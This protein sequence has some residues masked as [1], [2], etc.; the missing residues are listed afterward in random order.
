MQKL[1]Q[2]HSE[3]YSSFISNLEKG[4]FDKSQEELEYISGYLDKHIY[5]GFN[6]IITTFSPWPGKYKLVDEFWA[7]GWGD[8]DDGNIQVQ[9]SVKNVE[10]IQNAEVSSNAV[11]I[12]KE[13]DPLLGNQE[14]VFD[15][16][17]QD[18]KC[19]E[20]FGYS[21]K[22]Y[23]RAFRNDDNGNLKCECGAAHAEYK[24]VQ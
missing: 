4:D 19:F 10:I 20:N 15:Q 16:W 2:D 13:K 14:I 18:K 22:E 7:L 3:H 24:K 11:M 8:A 17:D 23:L 12:V 5:D 21:S 9:V 6:D 1:S